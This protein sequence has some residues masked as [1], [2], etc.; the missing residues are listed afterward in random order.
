MGERTPLALINPAASGR[1]AIGEA[2]TNIAASHIGSISDIKLSA[3]WMAAAGHNGEDAALYDTVQAVGEALCPAL[4]IAIPA[5]KDSLSMKTVWESDEGTRSMSAP[6]S[7]IISAF[8]ATCDVRKTLT[9]QLRDDCGPSELWLIDL[10]CGKNRLGGSALAQVY[11]QVGNVC[12][13]VDSSEQLKQFFNAIQALN[14]RSLL[15]AYHD[16]SDGG[17][18]TCLC[19]MAFAGNLGITLEIPQDGDTLSFLFSEELGAV[20]QIRTQNSQ[21]VQALLAAHQLADCSKRVATLN[22]QRNVLITQKVKN[23]EAGVTLYQNT[24]QA[25]R[26]SWWETSY[27]M[28]RLRD[29]PACADQEFSHISQSDDPGINVHINFDLH[30]DIA[31]PY[32]RREV[33]PRIAIV[34]EQGVNSQVEMA[35]AFDR[36]G[37][38]PIDVHMSDIIAGKRS[39]D[40]FRGLVAC[41]GF[42]YGDVLGGGGGWANTI[43]HNARAHDEFA[44]FFERSDVFGL[45]VCNGC[46]MFSQLGDLIPGAGHWPRFKR[47]ASEQYEARF[48]VVE[49]QA[50]N[51]ILLRGMQGS[52][53]PV[54]VAHGEGRAVFDSPH[55]QAK[56]PVALRFV[57]NH[58]A[59]TQNYPANPNG[60]PEGISGLCN[61]DGRFTI[62]MPHPERVFRSVLNSW[63]PDD[64]PED[65]PWMRLF[66]NARVWVSEL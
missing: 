8:A 33:R 44:Q 23:D 11:Q 13:D 36:A 29:N 31:A 10:G 26:R 5:G 40:S 16:R 59:V 34:R 45:G 3:N 48:S 15:Q 1:M 6:L 28:Q 49:V 14:Q 7:L 21:A 37:F 54:A 55:A 9:P 25:L 24:L 46:Q 60:S 66:R 38:N 47:N 22:T 53:I 57:D 32:I 18:F 63:H 52:R 65:G 56:A 35:V 64:W 30:E 20:I 61:E 2:L 41:G 39:L 50:S 19:E 27:Q 43:L 42:S 58:G 17:V 12:P 62:M 51:S 4:G